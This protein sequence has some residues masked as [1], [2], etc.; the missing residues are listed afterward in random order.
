MTCES[1]RVFEGSAGRTIPITP[2]SRDAAAGVFQNAG[3]L[4]DFNSLQNAVRRQPFR[5]I[6][7]C[8]ADGRTVEIRHPECMA[9]NKRV[10]IIIDDNSFTQTIEQLSI[11]SLEDLRQPPK[12]GNGAHGRK[13]KR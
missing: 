13:P 2:G 6:N 8:L 4:M 3:P 11:V 10:V 1:G 12:G 7:L 5:P 9:M